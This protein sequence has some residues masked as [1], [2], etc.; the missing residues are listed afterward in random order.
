[1][2]SNTTTP[3]L[4]R[5]ALQVA[6]THMGQLA[7]PTIIYGSCV[8][9]SYALLITLM[10]QQE[11]PLWFGAI[12]STLL[13]YLA[14]TTVHES[15]HNNI[16]GKHAK[17]RWLN[18]TLGYLSAIILFF[19]LT[20]HRVEHLAHHRHTNHPDNDP[21]AVL[22]GCGNSPVKVLRAAVKI[23]IT[24]YSHYLTTRWSKA[25]VKEKAIF[26]TEIAAASMLRLL[27]ISQ[28]LWAETLVLFV[29]GNLAGLSITLYLFAYIVHHPHDNPERYEGTSTIRIPG[30][31]NS[32]LTGIWVYQ[33]YHSIHHLFPRVPFYRYRKVFDEIEPIMRAKQA[34][35]YQLT[36][37]GLQADNPAME[38]AVNI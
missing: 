13:T 30:M 4:D 17:W 18:E 37:T 26:V 29:F 21:D 3:N 34:P 35:I 12:A 31:L 23:F 10:F 8:V 1:M 22:A 25:P 2:N 6:T 36:A 16:C 32:L 7:W 27:F 20:A 19:P 33:N 24:Q 28:G 9:A 5:Q 14:Y 15:A 11:I 38:N